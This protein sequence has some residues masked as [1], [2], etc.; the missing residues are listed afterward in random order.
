MNAY[1]N[2]TVLP[3]FTFYLLASSIQYL[4]DFPRD[5]Q[6]IVLYQLKKQNSLGT[7]LQFMFSG[8]EYKSARFIPYHFGVYRIS[9]DTVSTYLYT[10]IVSILVD[11]REVELLICCNSVTFVELHRFNL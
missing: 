11:S 10:L 4:Y 6:L 2:H 5:P 8:L 3:S 1:Y 9:M 7:I